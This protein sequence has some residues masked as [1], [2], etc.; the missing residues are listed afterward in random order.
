M[1][2]QL[3]H[4]RPIIEVRDGV[5]SQLERVRTRRSVLE[6]L[7]QLAHGLGPLDALAIQHTRAY[8]DARTMADELAAV[9]SIKEPVVVCEA[10]TTIGTHIGPRGLGVIAVKANA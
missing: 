9:L 5:A 6:R 4:I 10:T 8:D 2:G 7:K 3:L 1:L